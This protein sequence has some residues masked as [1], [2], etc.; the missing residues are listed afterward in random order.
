LC[1]ELVI[2]IDFSTLFTG[3]WHCLESCWQ[4]DWGG[5]CCQENLWCI[6]ESDRCP[7]NY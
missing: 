1:F 5:C 4:T 6:Q 7:G 3:L 2:V